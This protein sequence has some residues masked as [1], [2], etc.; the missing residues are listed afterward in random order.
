MQNKNWLV[1]IRV[2]S[3]LDEC[4]YLDMV[5]ARLNEADMNFLISFFEQ[6]KSVA[7][8]AP[9]DTPAIHMYFNVVQTS[10]QNAVEDLAYYKEFFCETPVGLHGI[11]CLG[12]YDQNRL[13]QIM[14]E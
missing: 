1:V 13:I 11:E 7:G 3:N 4:E 5:E 14:Q 12:E 6:I 9:W 8:N 2:K 10:A